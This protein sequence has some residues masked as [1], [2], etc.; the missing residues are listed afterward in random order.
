MATQTD[1]KVHIGERGYALGLAGFI[2]SFFFGLVGLILSIIAR[3]QSKKIGKKNTF[4][5][6]GIIIGIVQTV[7]S[8]LSAVFIVIT[9]AT[10]VNY[11]VQHQNTADSCSESGSSSQN[12]QY[13][14]SDDGQGQ[15][16]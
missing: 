1:E 7:L 10:V 4:A 14:G 8:A 3:S 2:T 11:C 16:Y 12:G 6:V 15:T 13:D 9:F 5:F